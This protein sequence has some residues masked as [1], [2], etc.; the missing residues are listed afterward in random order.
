MST[1]LRLREANLIVYLTTRDTGIVPR[2]TMDELLYFLDVLTG[3]SPGSAYII[4]PDPRWYDRISSL[5]RN[6]YDTLSTR[7][8]EPTDFVDPRTCQEVLYELQREFSQF[9]LYVLPLG[10]EALGELFRHTGRSS[11]GQELIFT[12]EFYRNEDLRFFDP[13]PPIR[14]LAGRTED[15]PGV[16]FWLPHGESVFAPL[17]KAER[18]FSELSNALEH[19][20]HTLHQ[21]ISEYNR[22]RSGVVQR[23]LLHLSDLHFGNRA[24][25]NNE[26]Y[27]TTHIQ[28]ILGE[29]DRVVITGDLFDNPEEEDYRGFYRF[30]IFLKNHTGKDPILVPG[31]HDQRRFGNSF[32]RIGKEFSQLANLRWN[33]VVIDDD[34]YCTFLCFNSSE[35]GN[36]A[37]GSI[38]RNQLRDVAT[39][40]E[41]R[42]LTHPALNEFV[43]IAVMHHHPY[44]FEGAEKQISRS[45]WRRG[46]RKETF[47]GMDNSE[48]FLK[49]CAARNVPLVMHGHKHEPR[50]IS[51]W[52]TLSTG[53][54]RQVTA[55]GCGASLG[56]GERPMSYNMLT[57]VPSSQTWSVRFMIDPG[58]GS[59]FE[60]DYIALQEARAV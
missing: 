29:F 17:R 3:L 1:P 21:L 36:W 46:I 27:L 15:W 38:S 6:A 8:Y 45:L 49:W 33:P 2:F 24:A 50:F 20:A 60:E 10:E 34:L 59:G 4:A 56:I 44:P 11:Q 30:L 25:L 26:P 53:S 28:S 58:D 48:R 42:K 39:E 16:L 18:I 31:N 43:K 7:R 19:G 32:A 13:L 55:V 23:R 57:W 51:D 22:S 37:R 47:V 5:A 54:Y 41:S 35:G 40:Y 9:D 12:P 52:I 14:Q